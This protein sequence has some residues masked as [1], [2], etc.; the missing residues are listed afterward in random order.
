LKSNTGGLSEITAKELA[1]LW[2]KQK[3]RCAL[4]GEKLNPDNASVDHIVARTKGGSEA[5]SNL[6]WTTKIVN[7]A[8]NN[9]SDEEF[10][11]LCAAVV[12]CVDDRRLNVV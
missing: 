10:L 7:H 4:T 6:R 5:I 8:K 12:R 3:G 9:L 2:R 11:R 1:S